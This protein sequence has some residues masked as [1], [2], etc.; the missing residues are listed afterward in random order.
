MM[1]RNQERTMIFGKAP[2]N[3]MMRTAAKE[4]AIFSLFESFR[5]H[6]GEFLVV[7][8]TENSHW[9]SD[10]ISYIG[11]NLMDELVLIRLNK[12]KQ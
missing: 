4:W 8:I 7:W 6:L 11:F 3:R 9:L 10:E 5:S 12:L 1:F 2:T